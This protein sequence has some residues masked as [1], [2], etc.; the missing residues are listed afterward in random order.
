M[1]H[2][3]CLLVFFCFR[4]H[5]H[6]QQQ[7]TQVSNSRYSVSFTA[8]NDGFS[9]QLLDSKTTYNFSFPSFEINGKQLP[10]VL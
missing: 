6:A 10:A 7:P 3:F 2:L 5:C 1:K 8:S 9:Y 4:F